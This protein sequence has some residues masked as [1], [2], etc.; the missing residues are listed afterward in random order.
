LLFVPLNFRTKTGEKSTLMAVQFLGT[1]I[2]SILPTITV[3]DWQQAACLQ[4]LTAKLDI[5]YDCPVEF[6][7][8]WWIL[9][10]SGEINP[11]SEWRRFDEKMLASQAILLSDL[12]EKEI[13]EKILSKEFI[14]TFNYIKSIKDSKKRREWI[15]NAFPSPFDS[16]YSKYKNDCHI[17]I[18]DFLNSECLN[19]TN[20][21]TLGY[22]ITF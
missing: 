10:D 8:K 12:S 6:K 16:N 15:F 19:G 21:E 2:L 13:K 4:S 5:D 17:A 7:E 18:D 3:K 11:R 20:L 22:A 9:I 1:I 14:H